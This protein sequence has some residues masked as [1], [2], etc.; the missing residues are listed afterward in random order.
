MRHHKLPFARRV[1]ILTVLCVVLAACGTSGGGTDTT[2]AAGETTETTASDTSAEST[3]PE[4]T[5]GDTTTP[6]TTAGTGAGEEGPIKV[7]VLNPTSGDF[8]FFGEQ[9]N[10][11]IQLYFNE[12]DNTV[13][14]RPVELVYGDTAGDPQ[15]GLEQARRLVEDEEVDVLVGLINSAV[16]VALADYADSAGV[17]LVVTVGSA[18]EITQPENASDWVNRVSVAS[19][20]E[21]RPLGWYTAS[22][23]GYT[24]VATVTWDFLAG[25]ERAAAFTETF[26]AA[27]GEVVSEQKPPP[28]STEYGSFLSAIDPGGTDAMYIFSAGPGSIAF[29]QQVEEFGLGE[30]VPLGSGF[31]TA[32][33]L[34]EIGTD[35]LGL[36]QAGQYVPSIDTPENQEFVTAFSE[37]FDVEG[38]VYSSQ[39]YIGAKAV[40]LGI[41]SLEGDTSDPAAL[42]STIRSLEFD[43]PAGPMSF[44]ENGQVVRNIYITEVVE[45]DDGVTQNLIDVIEGVDQFWTP[46]A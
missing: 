43:G 37:E 44:D 3:A 6:E 46:D 32:G 35:A 24:S 18:S 30:I 11:G 10:L 4:T 39:G 33:V 26:T 42:A 1:I 22:E 23:L 29:F 21:E 17:P 45:S 36:I 7:G 20:Q 38:G 27:G 12:V 8:A 31:I 15:Q 40:V 25:D 41:E 14:G 5:A 2:V 34:G 28:N 9:S 16:V 19:G 13:A